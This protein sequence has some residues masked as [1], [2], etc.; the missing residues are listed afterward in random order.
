[1]IQATNMEIFA[2]DAFIYENV[3]KVATAQSY[4]GPTSMCAWLPLVFVQFNVSWRDLVF[5]RYGEVLKST[6]CEDFSTG[7]ETQHGEIW[8]YTNILDNNL[9]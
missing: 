1:M 9:T 4:G 5:T 2:D 3:D 7:V 8:K 6:R